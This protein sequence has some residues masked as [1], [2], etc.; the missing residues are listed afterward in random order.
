[1]PLVLKSCIIS[2]LFKIFDADD[3]GKLSRK[4]LEDTLKLMLGTESGELDLESLID[5]VFEEVDNSE[6][7]FIDKDGKLYSDFAKVM[8]MTNFDQKCSFY[9]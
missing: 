8:W 2:V 9:F 3:D 1:M 6:K 4:D 5:K 7:N